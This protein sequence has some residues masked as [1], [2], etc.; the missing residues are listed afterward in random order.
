MCCKEGVVERVKVGGQMLLSTVEDVRAAA[1]AGYH[2]VLSLGPAD[3]L[4][5][6]VASLAPITLLLNVRKEKNLTK[7]M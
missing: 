2:C 4:R 3:L 6:T 1:A 7:I 5:T